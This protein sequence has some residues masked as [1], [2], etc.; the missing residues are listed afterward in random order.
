[1][2]TLLLIIPV[3]GSFFI[4]SIQENSLNGKSKMRT[5]AITT[6]L[7]NLLISIFL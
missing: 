3:I 7:I 6:S 4:L 2:L 1:M 5:I